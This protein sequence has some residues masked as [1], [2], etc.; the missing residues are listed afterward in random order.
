MISALLK[1][2]RLL[3]SKIDPGRLFESRTIR[4]GKEYLYVLHFAGLTYSL[5]GWLGRVE[6]HL[7]NSKRSSKLSL[8]MP[9]TIL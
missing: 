2:L 7:V 5:F 3:A 6:L 4:I 8:F 1:R 9:K